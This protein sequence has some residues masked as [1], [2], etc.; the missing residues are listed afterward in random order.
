MRGYI[1]DHPNM[2][3]FV[4]LYA[5]LRPNSLVAAQTVALASRSASVISIRLE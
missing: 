1:D 3:P 4:M 5:S 2:S